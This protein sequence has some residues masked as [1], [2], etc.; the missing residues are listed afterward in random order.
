MY[1]V[2]TIVYVDICIGFLFSFY[3]TSVCI[4]GGGSRREQINVVGKGVEIVIATPGRL[5]D[6][7]M[8]KYIDISSVTFL[9]S[10]NAKF[11]LMLIQIAQLNTLEIRNENLPPMR[12]FLLIVQIRWQKKVKV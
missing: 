4:Y 12:P 8:N 1:A 6:L 10:C 3:Q 7:V 9:V 5:N 2:Y 11:N